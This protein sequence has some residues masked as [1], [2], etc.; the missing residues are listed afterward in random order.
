[1]SRLETFIDIM[2]KRMGF[3]RLSAIKSASSSARWS[4][5][6]GLSHMNI[7]A[8]QNPKAGN[9]AAQQAV[10]SPI[11]ASMRRGF[12]AATVGTGF[13]AEPLH[14]SERMRARVG[15]LWAETA[16]ELE[17]SGLD[18]N[19]L[20]STTAGSIFMRGEAIWRRVIVDDTGRYARLKIQVIPSSQMPI[21]ETRQ[22]QGSAFI[23]H[24]IEFDAIGRPV[25]YHILP[26]APQHLLPPLAQKPIRLNAREIAFAAHR[27]EPGQTRGLSILGPALPTIN[28][29]EALNENALAKHRLGSALTVFI[30]D[31][32]GS[33][34]N[35]QI[36]EKDAQTGEYVVHPGQANVLRPGQDVEIPNGPNT[37][38]YQQVAK[39]L[40]RQASSAVGLSPYQVDGD[41][42]DANYSSLRAG[43]LEH[44]RFVEQFQ[45]SVLINQLCNTVWA[46]FIDV[47]ILNGRLPAGQRDELLK[48]RW[49]PPRAES[50]D[51]QKDA[52][53]DEVLLR[54]RLRSRSE[55]ISERG[56]SI[57]QVDQ[58]FGAD[59][60]F[61]TTQPRAREASDDS[62]D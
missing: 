30:R 44:L 55:L 62:E 29:L 16:K 19:T 38:D 46:W 6:P 17:I 18:F 10:N 20:L 1:M 13:K 59:R 41:L 5:N 27:L 8:G 4:G 51:P 53:A 54:N 45:Q 56:G 58:D 57:E 3:E 23:L 43:R 61:A 7:A 36:F 21:S 37:G 9:R 47:E 33:S 25:A 42:S 24:G 39:T 52:N 12:T 2:A 26:R 14:A 60:Y 40:L 50:I 32:D 22:L 28:E 48:V 35:E 11:A 34:I 15:L 49:I 31:A